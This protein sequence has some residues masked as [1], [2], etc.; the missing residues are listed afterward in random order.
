[1]EISNYHHCYAFESLQWFLDDIMKAHEQSFLLLLV[2]GK[3]K[4]I[5]NLTVN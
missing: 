1:M 2:L 4:Q 3:E 5:L